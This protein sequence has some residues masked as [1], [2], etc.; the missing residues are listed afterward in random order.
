MSDKKNIDRLF[1]ENLKD[2]EVTPND[3]VWENIH[4]TL[5]KDKRKRRILIPLWWRVAGVAALMVLMF[6][7]ANALLKETD[8]KTNLPVVNSSTNDILD[9]NSTNEL[10]SEALKKEPVSNTDFD[11]SD[12]SKSNDDLVQNPNRDKNTNLTTPGN[13]NPNIVASNT[14]KNGENLKSNT[15]DSNASATQKPNNSTGKNTKY[16]VAKK[17]SNL[18]EPNPNVIL[19]NELEPLDLNSKESPENAI[20]KQTEQIPLNE[21]ESISEQD[22]LAET[23]E[24]PSI[25]DAMA[26]AENTNEKEKEEEKLNRWNISPSVAPVYF[27]TLGEGSSIHEQFIG[28]TKNGDLN[29]SY[30]LGGSYALNEKLKI[31]AGIHKV[32]LGYSTNNVI[33]YSGIGARNGAGSNIKYNNNSKATIFISAESINLTS[34]P[35]ILNTNIK[36]S[37]EQQLGFIEIPLEVEYSLINKKIG[38]NV[39]GGFSTLFLSKNEIYS[40]LEGERTLIGEATNINSTSYSANLGVG[41]NYNV[42]EKIKINLEPMFKY[43]INTFNNSSGDFQPYFIGVYT[44]L[45]Y[46]F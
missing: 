23:D 4:N 11:V 30:G 21:N 17:S 9:K 35:E 25:E 20:A 27:N 6:T 28:N 24:S 13:N 8:N 14:T 41:V 43:Q 45:S 2:F 31:R 19:K 42:S 32:N 36:G 22:I 40:N 7:I 5:H 10:E 3:A 16:T 38:L 18:P 12:Q 15:S 37:L 46:K 44:G 39:I 33:V 29:M 26:L 34:A 1:Q